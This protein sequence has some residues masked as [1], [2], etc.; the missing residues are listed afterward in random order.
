[1]HESHKNQSALL[2]S[3]LAAR[4]PRLPST[5]PNVWCIIVNWNGWEDTLHC[6]DSLKR[7]TYPNL[8]P[9]I[10]DN[11]S[12]DDSVPKLREAHPDLLVLESASNLGFAGGNNIGI[13]YALAHSADYVWLLNND[14]APE[15][16]ALASLVAKAA[17]NER[18]GAVAS[19]CYHANNQSSVEAWGGAHVNL[20]VGFGRNSRRPRPD[21][22]FHSLNGTS[23]LISR[24]ALEDV[25]LLDEIFFLYWED[26][27]FCLRL[28]KK[29]WKIAAAPDSRVLHK[30]HGSTGDNKVALDRYQTASG[31]RLLR[32]HSPL[33]Y[34]S[35][36]LFLTMRFTKRILQL[37]FARCRSVWLGIEDYRQKLSAPPK[38]R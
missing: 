23:M 35:M 25:G 12:T 33:P 18:I 38:I 3:E 20:W 22:W 28:R 29:Q 1:M 19:I 36:F 30:V 15:P 32:L 14:T 26:T 37:Q 16:E 10:I 8:M 11:G 5:A 34:V 17:T 31:L 2:P 6:L 21:E 7:C 27:E 13:R 24:E 9:V 4:A